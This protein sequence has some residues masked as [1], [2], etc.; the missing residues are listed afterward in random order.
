ME[1][2]K[3]EHGAGTRCQEPPGNETH[4][5]GMRLTNARVACA[6]A[7][8]AVVFA[9]LALRAA[10]AQKGPKKG[11]GTNNHFLST[12]HAVGLQPDTGTFAC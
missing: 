8:V 5:D 9:A 2:L 11:K 6:Q 12:L 10:E 4:P 1:L 7:V 3:R